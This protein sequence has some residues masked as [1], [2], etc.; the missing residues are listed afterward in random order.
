MWLDLTRNMCAH[1]CSGVRGKERKG[2]GSK[3]VLIHPDPLLYKSVSAINACSHFAVTKPKCKPIG[4]SAV[5]G[6]LLF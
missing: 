3:S 1:V 4:M 5:C 6:P 2:N